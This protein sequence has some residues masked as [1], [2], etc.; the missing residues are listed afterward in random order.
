MDYTYALASAE[1]DIGVA[2]WMSMPIVELFEW[3]SV[4]AER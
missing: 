3:R 4:V 1:P 2:E